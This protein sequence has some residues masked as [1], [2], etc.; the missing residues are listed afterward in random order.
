MGA[1]CSRASNSK[2]EIAKPETQRNSEDKNTPNEVESAKPV[3]SS[4]EIAVR[5]IPVTYTPHQHASMTLRIGTTSIVIDPTLSGLEQLA[6]NE[7]KNPAI[8]LVTDIHGDHL[9]PKA[10]QR[11][12]GSETRVIAPAAPRLTTS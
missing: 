7:P 2:D 1:G 4:D 10:I 8:I 3:K 11:I 12:R 9:D 6:G 5:E